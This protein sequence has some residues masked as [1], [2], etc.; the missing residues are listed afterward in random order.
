MIA[1][2]VA[3]GQAVAACEILTDG[4]Y[5]MTSVCCVAQSL[6]VLSEQSLTQLLARQVLNCGQLGQ[7]P[8]PAAQVP[9]QPSAAPQI[10][11][12]QLGVHDVQPDP[13]THTLP[14]PSASPHGLPAQT[15][16]HA[17]GV[18]PDPAT[19]APPQPSPWPQTTPLQLGVH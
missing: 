18:Q 12:A 9:P 15:G 7:H 11:S 5:Q 14:Q 4:P 1:K 3:C 10:A 17:D 19:Q 6:N 2:C 8:E 13:A 16:V